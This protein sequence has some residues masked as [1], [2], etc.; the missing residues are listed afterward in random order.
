MPK[1]IKELLDARY[2][3]RRPT[4][5]AVVTAM[6]LDADG[7]SKGYVVA[8]VAGYP[9]EHVLIGPNDTY[10]VGDAIIVEQIG[11][12][13]MAYYRAQGTT[14]PT[15]RGATGFYSFTDTTTLSGSTY[16]AGDVVIGDP[17]SAH[18]VFTSGSIGFKY[19]SSLLQT[20]SSSGLQFPS[21]VKKLWT[22]TLVVDS[23]GKGDYTSVKAAC[24]YVAT[25]SPSTAA[26]WTILITPGNYSESPFT[27]PTYTTLWG[28]GVQ[29]TNSITWT[30]KITASAN[31]TSGAFITMAL[32]AAIEGC[33]IEATADAAA[34]ATCFV[35]SGA[36]AIRLN[37]SYVNALNNGTT[38]RNIGVS[39]V[40]LANLLIVRSGN[41]Y[42]TCIESLGVSV[43]S[44]SWLLATTASNSTG[45]IQ[46]TG[47]AGLVNCRFGGSTGTMFTLDV[48][49]TG[50]AVY[51]NGTI[52]KTY[53]GTVYFLDRFMTTGQGTREAAA[54]TDIPLTIKGATSQSANLTE[55]QDSTAAVL[56]T[57]DAAGKFGIGTAPAC[58]LHAVVD[59]ATIDAAVEVLRVA[60]TTTGTAAAGI[61]TAITLYAEDA[62]G[63]VDEAGRI[64][65]SFPIA[66]HATQTGRV[67]IT[68]LGAAAGTGLAVLSNGWVGI[69]T[70]GPAGV[71]H[72]YSA[73]AGA[74]TP[75]VGGDE[76]VIE[77][78]DATGLS[79]LSPDASNANLFFG[80]PAKA[81]GAYLRWNYNANNFIVGPNVTSATTTIL[82]GLS[83]T[84]IT[85]NAGKVGIGTTAPDTLLHGLLTDAGTA[86]VV[87][88]LTVGHE[89]SGT[90]AAGFGAGIHM[91]LE[92]S[93]TT[94]Q[95]AAL[96]AASW[97]VATHASRTA[98]LALSVYDSAG[99]REGIR[100]DADGTVAR[101]G[102]YGV[103]AV[104]RPTALT[105]ALTDLTHTAPGTPDYAIQD[106]V[107]NTGFG[108][109]TK[110]E[111]N[112]VLTVIQ[113]IK[114][115][116][117]DLE[118]RLTGLGLLT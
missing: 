25:Q 32:Y 63:N 1:T 28:L 105:T 91:T 113:N 10:Y 103:T 23:G 15:R 81:L 82:Y 97:I 47:N 118:T 12:P 37:R 79:I 45:L 99:A 57:V 19:S 34:S 55:W 4:L 59:D 46:T 68:A 76:L 20:W 89:S 87:N 75:N 102:F 65:A 11:T 116:L 42:T 83:Q 94:K 114:V 61:G 5:Q 101:L 78:S 33:Y 24:D 49:V 52:F 53:S 36:S 40:L 41:Q 60:H 77:N 100:I 95:S 44:Y 66:L 74:V 86:A 54:A 72:I 39:G 3:M 31:L 16:Q 22:R 13:G 7:K 9:N 90:P 80:S 21:G 43:I 117:A 108:F 73:S 2:E 30:V 56:A 109:V 104:V 93:T 92:S 17:A 67:D 35:V 70:T 96:L 29:P 85:I 8:T 69:G 71:L 48:E 110:D 38:Y 84:G 112:T 88:V 106:L 50:G 27:I 64:R 18:G 6:P 111:G 58:T 115:R 98:R 51:S 26:R 107:Q 62:S 14:A